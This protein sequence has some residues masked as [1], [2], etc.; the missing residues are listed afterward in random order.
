MQEIVRLHGGTVTVDSTAGVG[1]IFTVNVPISATPAATEP[2]GAPRV[3]LSTSVSADAYVSEALGWVGVADD[4]GGSL[5]P[6]DARDARILLA[7]DNADMRAYVGRLLGERWRVEAVGDGAA[8]LAAAHREPPDVIVADVMM[9]ELDGFELLAAL[10]ADSATRDIP[11]VLL[12]AR[13]GEEATLKGIAAGADDYLVKPFTARDLLARVE[14]QL[15]RARARE[16]AAE[17]M[18]Q[19]ESLL[20]HA[21]LGVYLV[22]EDLRVAYVNPLAAP[23]FGDIPDLVGRDFAD[24]VHRLWA[25]GLRRRACPDLPAHSRNG[26][27][28]H[29]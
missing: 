2:I 17:R 8:A 12:S 5:A 10:R 19:V 28:V 9:P 25:R 4:P 18:A 23:V 29:R 16:A 15:S 22:D 3:A 20:A 13:A 6:V 24:V 26:R 11:V 14:A 1:T 27:D 21:P 7:D